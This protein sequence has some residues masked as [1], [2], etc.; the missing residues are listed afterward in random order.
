MAATL[1]AW[2]GRGQRRYAAGPASG[3]DDVRDPRVPAGDGS[4]A[5]GASESRGEATVPTGVGP[6]GHNPLFEPQSRRQRL[7]RRL[8][9]ERRGIGIARR[10]V[11]EAHLRKVRAG[12][13]LTKLPFSAPTAKPRIRF[14]RVTRAMTELQWGDPK[15]A[16]APALDSKLPLHEVHTVVHGHATRTFEKH[17][18]RVGP[19][20]HCFSLVSHG[21]E[22][23]PRRGNRGRREPV[24]R[25]ARRPRRTRQRSARH[26]GRGR[27]REAP[28][29]PSSP[30]PPSRAGSDPESVARRVLDVHRRSPG[31]SG[32]P[33]RARPHGRPRILAEFLPL[34]WDRKHVVH[35]DAG[36]ART[37]ARGRVRIRRVWGSKS[38]TTDAGRK[39]GTTDAGTVASRAA[40]A[41]FT[42]APAGSLSRQNSLEAERRERLSRPSGDAAPLRRCSSSRGVAPARLAGG[43]TRGGIVRRS[44]GGA[45]LGM[46]TGTRTG[47]GFARGQRTPR[48]RG[49]SSSLGSIGRFANRG[50]GGEAPPRRRARD[51]ARALAPRVSRV[52]RARVRRRRASRGGVQPRSSRSREGSRRALFARGV[53]PAARISNGL[54]L[55]HMAAQNNQRKSAKLVLKRTDFASDPPRL[56]LIDAQTNQGQTP[57]H[58]CFAYG[59]RDLARYLLSLGA[60]DAVTNVHGM[61][62]YEGTGPGRTPARDAARRGKSWSWR[63]VNARNDARS[64]FDREPG[65][66]R[67][68]SSAEPCGRRP[69][70]RQVRRR[71]R[72]RSVRPERGRGRVRVLAPR[73]PAPHY[74]SPR[75]PAP[76]SAADTRPRPRGRRRRAIPTRLR[77]ARRGSQFPNPY[78]PYHA[79]HPYVHP[80]THANPYAAMSPFGGG[81]YPM[82]PTALAVQAMAAPRAAAL[83]A[84]TGAAGHGAVGAVGAMGAMGAMGAAGG[85]G[86][87]GASGSAGVTVGIGRR[88]GVSVAPSRERLAREVIRP[89]STPRTRTRAAARRRAA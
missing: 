47:R 16:A 4:G 38:G 18:K 35:P 80:H 26:R 83:A 23:R 15:D 48:G 8:E 88:R 56:S 12:G 66:R 54:T 55:L 51:D 37:A 31:A 2:R 39:S 42:P 74:S 63:D 25:G 34:G 52:A 64:R 57:L 73:S 46:G 22:A 79:P 41:V 87:M 67:G 32:A 70:A 60:D 44:R 77:T 24:V 49:A 29:T 59:Y 5:P 33:A 13:L 36:R 14:F 30:Y 75:S 85:A 62:C 43:G 3:R 61:T 6:G 69:E 82:D 58:F 19:P 11:P 9:R 40:P 28:V 81:G 45:A 1:G 84:M 65:T 86:A 20:S 21:R 27:R 72:P 17:R 7:R 78:G 76:W 53:D 68:V 89:T 71:R 10:D 50:D